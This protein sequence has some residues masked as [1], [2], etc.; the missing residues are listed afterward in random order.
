LKSPEDIEKMEKEP[1]YLR[2][3][4]KLSDSEPSDDTQISKFTLSDDENNG[5]TLRENNS[6]LHDNVD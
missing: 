5:T 3:N 2:R 4:V 1:A 6:F